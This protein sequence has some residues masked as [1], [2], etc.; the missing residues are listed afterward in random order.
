MFFCMCVYLA[1][2]LSKAFLII[3]YEVSFL[4]SVNILITLT[5]LF[6]RSILSDCVGITYSTRQC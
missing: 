3:G 2:V 4:S 5:V 6:K 1:Q